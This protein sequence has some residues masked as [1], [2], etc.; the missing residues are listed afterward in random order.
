MLLNV[1]G[2]QTVDVSTVRRCVVSFSS[3]DSDVKDKPRSGRSCTAARCPGFPGNRTN[4]QLWTL[5]PDAKL[6]NRISRVRLE[7]KP[8]FLL[9]HDNARPYT[10]RLPTVL[11]GF[12]AFSLPSVGADER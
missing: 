11:S 3:G 2:A 4:R 8:T 5:H 10:I 12:G 1:Y 7:K 6:M 9:E